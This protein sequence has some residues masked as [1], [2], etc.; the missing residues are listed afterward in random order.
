M[1][2]TPTDLFLPARLHRSFLHAFVVRADLVAPWA[3]ELFGY[4]H[5]GGVWENFAPPN[6]APLQ[7]KKKPKQVS[8]LH[9][10]PPLISSTPPF[11][12]S[13]SRGAPPICGAGGVVDNYPPTTSYNPLVPVRSGKKEKSTASSPTRAPFPPPRHETSNAAFGHPR[14]R[15][16][17]L[18]RRIWFLT[19]IGT[20]RS[21]AAAA[22]SESS[23]GIESSTTRSLGK[24]RTRGRRGIERGQDRRILPRRRQRGGGLGLW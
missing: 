18:R 9:S 22:A 10:I 24:V 12:G 11:F 13:S 20:S 6:I 5:L 8:Q 15:R 3:L 4:N 1:S 16:K 17:R 19:A 21:H 7:G 2:T 23:T 14:R